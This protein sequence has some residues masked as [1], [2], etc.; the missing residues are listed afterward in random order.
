[1][2]ARYGLF[3]LLIALMIGIGLVII[4]WRNQPH[5]VSSSPESGAVNVPSAAQIHIEFS[6]S[7]LRETITKRFTT[8]PTV[9]GTFSWDENTLT[10]TPDDS[11]PAGQ[12]IRVKLA[13]GARASNWLAFP[14]GSYS[15]SY[16]TDVTTLVYLWPSNGP[17]DI[18]ALDPKS[19]EIIQYTHGANVLDY[20]VSSDGST[21]FFSASNAQGGADLYQLNRLQTLSSA[22]KSYEFVKLLDCSSAQCRSPAVS[23]DG[24]YLAYEYL[25][26]D[27]TGGLGPSQ[28]WEM[29]L[30]NQKTIQVGA[31][32]HET[33]QPGWSSTGWL[34]YYDR[35]TSTYEVVNPQNEASVHLANQTGQPGTWSPDGEFY[36]APELTYAPAIS[37]TETASSNLL[38]YSLNSSSSTNM[39]GESDVE[40][41]EGIY[42]SDGKSIAFA[43]KYLDASRWTLGRQIWIMN[44]DGSGAHPITD[45][46]DYN[47]YDLAWDLQSQ[48]L[49]YVRFN[50]AKLSDPPELWMIN[51]DGSDPLQL[52]IG[53]YSPQWIP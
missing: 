5:L 7:M 24:R 10:F 28:I 36:L 21:I 11:W 14:M 30:S 41:V 33:I 25:V 43:R 6:E 40:D 16:K 52:I 26:P 13:A 42:S 37:Q 49:A 18:Y 32:E 22:D 23:Q 12:D 17:S 27:P 9:Q 8:E 20:I 1:M 4:A 19:G 3:V 35:T 47:H 46:P 50:E 2:K 53:G 39:S 45:E 29:N 44:A 48:T 15:W 31:W 38:R 51:V 34:A